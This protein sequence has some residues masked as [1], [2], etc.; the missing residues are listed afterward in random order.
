[1]ASLPPKIDQRTYEEIVQQTEKLVEQS[2]D[3]KAAPGN[4]TDA[5]GALIRIFGR[6]VKFS[7]RSHQPSSR[8][9]FS[10]FP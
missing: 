3:W 2:T 7:Q 8:E 6:M 9:K 10:G 5:G 4:K 1:M